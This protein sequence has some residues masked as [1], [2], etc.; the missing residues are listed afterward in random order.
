MTKRTRLIILFVCVACF[1]IVAPI[2]VLYS[3]GD[4]FDFVKMKITATGG[5][6]VRTF[7]SADQI[8]IDSKFI[9]K[10]GMFSNSVFTQSLLPNQHTVLI[11]KAGYYDYSKTLPVEKKQVTKLENVLLFKKNIQFTVIENPTQSPFIDKEKYIIKNTNLYYSTAPEN[12]ELTTTQKVT[13][14]LKKIVAFTI[15]GN[16]ILWLGTDGFLY[17]SDPASALLPTKITLT[18]IKIIKTGSYKIIA[19]SN[20]VFVN[21]N[22]NLLLLNSKTNVLDVFSAS[23]VDAKISPDNK[24][25]VFYT[26]NSLYISPLPAALT[27]KVVLYNSAEKIKDCVWLNNDYIIFATENKIIISEID[28]RGSINAITMPQTIKTTEIENPQIF[29]NQQEGKLYIL[30]NNILLVSEKITPQ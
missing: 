7:P 5:I 14:V 20:S 27:L 19:N 25:I 12:S 16:N 30:T 22:G 29:F 4:R 18:P 11:K 6:Y 26:N 24:N 28:Y 10:P 9:E 3:M 23:V 13:P 8:L 2:L 1:F 17:K 21:D 15:L